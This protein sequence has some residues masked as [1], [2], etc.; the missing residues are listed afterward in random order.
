[1]F[2]FANPQVFKAAVFFPRAEFRFQICTL[3]LPLPT[4][5]CETKRAGRET[6]GWNQKKQVE[7]EGNHQMGV[8]KNR[9]KPPKSS[10][11]IGFGTIIFTI[12]FWGTIIFGNT[13][14]GCLF[15]RGFFYDL[16]NVINSSAWVKVEFGN[17]S[18]SLLPAAFPFRKPIFWL[19]KLEVDQLCLTKPPCSPK[20]ENRKEM[21]GSAGVKVWHD[22]CCFFVLNCVMFEIIRLASVGT[23]PI[24]IHI[25][26]RCFLYKL[27]MMIHCR[28]FCQEYFS[29]V[30]QQTSQEPYKDIW[31]HWIRIDSGCLSHLRSR[32]RKL[33]TLQND[34]L[35][36]GHGF[37]GDKFGW[38]NMS[39]D[40]QCH[41]SIC[42]FS[43]SFSL[44]WKII[45]IQITDHPW[46]RSNSYSWYDSWKPP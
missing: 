15:W 41:V 28:W 14:I 30:A 13:Q 45:W 12:H 5:T 27:D 9:G 23:N 1:M 35:S 39:F 33:A 6:N 37:T 26:T 42:S 19:R 38:W 24:R 29:M 44:C 34:Y 20:T 18:G 7:G 46:L 10:I 11:L 36:P 22:L 43:T 17:F 25:A 40:V 8:S 21:A 3:V 32:K 31:K 16:F 2:F 4:A